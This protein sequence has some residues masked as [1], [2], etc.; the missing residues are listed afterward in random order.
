[1]KRLQ[2][3]VDEERMEKIYTKIKHIYLRVSL[4]KQYNIYKTLVELKGIN[5][6]INFI[7]KDNLEDKII[8]TLISKLFNY[9]LEN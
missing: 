8:I 9:R 3:N 2:N 6:S 5:E 7:I 4:Q 1:M